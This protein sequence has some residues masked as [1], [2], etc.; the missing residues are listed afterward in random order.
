MVGFSF[1]RGRNWG[2]NNLV[3]SQLENLSLGPSQVKIQTQNSV[4]QGLLASMQGKKKKIWENSYTYSEASSSNFFF[5]DVFCEEEKS[6]WKRNKGETQSQNSGL[7]RTR[8]CLLRAPWTLLKGAFRCT[9]TACSAYL[10]IG[11]FT[12]RGTCGFFFFFLVHLFFGS[13]AHGILV[14]QPRLEPPTPTLKVWS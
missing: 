12:T 8:L 4:S 11:K 2:L 3:Q 13:K 10:I 1:C 6:L 9:S 14:P 5:S 7:W